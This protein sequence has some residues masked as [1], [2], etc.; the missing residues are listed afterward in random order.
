MGR[1]DAYFTGEEQK[2][3]LD[4]GAIIE[5]CFTTTYTNKAPWEV[6]FANIRQTGV[7]RSCIPTDLGQ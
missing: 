1:A 4:L 7:S 3:L 6:A 2:E 5:H